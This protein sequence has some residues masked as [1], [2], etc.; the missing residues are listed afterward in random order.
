[1]T[2]LQLKSLIK[3][4][5]ENYQNHIPSAA[6]GIL[7]NDFDKQTTSTS[8]KPK[9]AS[10]EIKKLYSVLKS[11]ERLAEDG[12][13]VRLNGD[14]VKVESEQKLLILTYKGNQ[15]YTLVTDKDTISLNYK[16][17]IKYLKNELYGER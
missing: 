17:M 14:T 4:V 15:L 13:I 9:I 2:K 1:M 11:S 12:F 8:N 6:D 3:E 5:M 10:T 7:E 16:D